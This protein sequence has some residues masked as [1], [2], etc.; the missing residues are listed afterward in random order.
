M[1]TIGLT[2][3]I[4]S[5]KS[6][7]ARLLAERGVPIVDADVLAREAVA[8][9]TPG[10]A[11]I[12]ERWGPKVIAHDGSID[13]AALRRIVFSD[14]AQLAA[15]NA[16][17]HPEVARRRKALVDLARGRGERIIVCDIP[18][19]FEAGLVA[20]VD[21]VLLVDAPEELRRDRLIRDRGLAPEEATA[22]IRAQMPAALKRA[23]ADFVIDNTGSPEE[24]RNRLDEVWGRIDVET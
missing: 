15:L 22:M 8:P 20:E 7:V 5:G 18:L 11:A 23:R 12:I 21:A 17:V 13:R 2:G 24:L 16:I 14:P 4:A 1:R 3:N 9:F 19:L 6:T 10:H